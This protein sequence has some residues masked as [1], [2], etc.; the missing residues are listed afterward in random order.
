M[1]KSRVEKLLVGRGHGSMLEGRQWR[2][3]NEKFKMKNAA[4][5]E[6]VRPA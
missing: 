1:Q 4:S 6:A 3:Q 2:I 5:W